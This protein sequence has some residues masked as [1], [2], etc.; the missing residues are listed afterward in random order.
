MTS[1][2]INSID[3]RILALSSQS[4]AIINLDRIWRWSMPAPG[5]WHTVLGMGILG[6]AMPI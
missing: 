4:W 2:A 3:L 1:L 5:E 6:A